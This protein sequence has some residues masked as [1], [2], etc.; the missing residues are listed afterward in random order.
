MS[1]TATT[2]R[3][4][5][6]GSVSPRVMLLAILLFAAS[7]LSAG[8]FRPL[9]DGESL[10][11][12]HGDSELWSVEHGVIVGTT[13]H[14]PIK[15]NTFLISDAKYGDFTLR[16]KFKLRNG[17]SGVQFR[18]EELPGFVVR[19]YQA[20]IADNQFMGILYDEK[21]RGI[22]VEVDPE[23]V[24]PHLKPND[25]N[26]YQITVDGPHITQELNGFKTVSY[27]EKSPRAPT[28][29][30]IALQLHVGPEMRVEFKDIELKTA[31]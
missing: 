23:Q 19:G 7:P 15:E 20:D 4:S 27:E 16:L 6:A 14:K 21:G 26:E 2:I 3:H 9:F 10:A 5:R 17:N 28:E 22:L 11:G 29:G 13:N 24:R 18:A 8:E 30:I 1:R 12:W 31:D 25:W